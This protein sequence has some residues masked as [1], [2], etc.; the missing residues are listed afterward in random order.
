MSQFRFDVLVILLCTY[1]FSLPTRG[2]A[3]G[4]LA[5]SSG[6][7][8]EWHSGFSYN[9][10]TSYDAQAA[11]LAKCSSSAGSSCKIV[12]QFANQCVVLA[13]TEGNNGSGRS[14]GDTLPEA[15]DKAI[16]ACEQIN[17]SRCRVAVAVCDGKSNC[18]LDCYGVWNRAQ[19]VCSDVYPGGN[20]I[21][22]LP[23]G[24]LLRIRAD[25]THCLNNSEY[26]NDLC[27]RSC[28]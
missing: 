14:V 4:A 22:S 11:A 28:R 16:G 2:L 26:V 18:T 19:A 20:V 8:G 23:S 27:V 1:Y 7:Q 5:F 6:G 12:E 13:I 21:G 9:N 25:R 24:S 15:E 3:D 17:H 10:H